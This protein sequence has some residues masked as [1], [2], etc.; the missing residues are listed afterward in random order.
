MGNFSELILSL[1]Q[2][3]H[4]AYLLIASPAGANQ[5]GFI[6]GWN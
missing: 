6:V 1:P 2:L 3:D 4:I 5:W